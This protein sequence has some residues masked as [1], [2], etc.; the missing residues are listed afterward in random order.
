[1][2]ELAPQRARPAVDEVL[3]QVTS[4]IDLL[5]RENRPVVAQALARQRDAHPDHAPVVVV[6]GED[7]RGK[8]SLVNALLAQR[9]LSPVGAKVVT[10]SPITFFHS[11]HPVASMLRYGSTDA[12]PLTVEQAQ[13][14]ATTE[15]NPGNAANISGIRIGLDL[16][17]LEAMD[18][19]DTPGVGGLA[20]GHAELTLQSLTNADALLFVVDSS[21]PLRASE[22][23]FLRRAAQRLQFVV[24]VVTKIDVNPGWRTIMGDDAAVLSEHA[25]RF[26]GC[27]IAAVSSAS[28]LRALTLDDDEFA[29]EIRV[30][31]GIAGLEQ[32]LRTEVAA[33]IDTVRLQNLLRS[34]ISSLVAL[35]WDLRER[36]AATSPDGKALAGLQQERA[37][38][39]ELREDKVT[40]PGRLEGQIRKLTLLRTD[41][42]ARRILEI[43]VRYQERARLADR[44]EIQSLP[45]E[46]LAELTALAGEL[47]ELAARQLAEVMSAVIDDMDT[48]STVLSGIHEIGAMS[49]ADQLMP[50]SAKD[51]KLRPGER[52][53]LLNEVGRGRSLM[54]LLSGKS[55]VAFLAPPFGL[56]LGAGLGSV[57][58][59]QAWREH[60]RH[61]AAAEFRVWMNEQITHAQL[62]INNG[63]ALRVVDLQNEMRVAIRRTLAERENAISKSVA[64]ALALQQQ[65]ASRQHEVRSRLER[66]IGAARK[67][68]QTSAKLLADLSLPVEVHLSLD[69]E[70]PS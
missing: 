7:K 42:C 40:W 38:L 44:N 13:L 49:V 67:L 27:P 62:T 6:A 56:V 53:Q 17:L 39:E 23:S 65:A 59:F 30:E 8:S 43:R 55:A 58:A 36:Q 60:A 31:S 54:G 28:T 12:E 52:V 3:R 33:S 10:G 47:N 63:F 37:R 4:V 45:G 50:F 61:G 68:R 69:G 24:L 34:G 29:A 57:F 15:G 19:I 46:L 70:D 18:L 22:L 64:S 35:E 11:T 20:S 1:M 48:S 26:A 25:P 21:S 5:D 41:T 66:Q 32:L 9:D 2:T 14:L 16:P 51:R